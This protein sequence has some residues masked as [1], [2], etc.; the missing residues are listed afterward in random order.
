[1]LLEVASFHQPHA[2]TAVLSRYHSGVP[3]DRV[4][5]E[6]IVDNR[7]RTIHDSIDLTV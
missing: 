6:M 4:T 7:S 3:A 2:G 1:M 5:F